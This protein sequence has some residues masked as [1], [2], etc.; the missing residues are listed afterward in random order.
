MSRKL[1]TTI[2]DIKGIP[3]KHKRVLLAWAAF[4]NN[5]GTNI[6]PAKERVAQKA[7]INRST[8]YH[9]TEDLIKVGILVQATSHTCKIAS[10]GKGGNHYT[11]K[12][13]R[14][15]VVYNLD[16]VKVQNS[17]T[18]L[19]LKQLK[20]CV[21]KQLKVNVANQLRVYVAKCDAT[22]ALDSTHASLGSE[23]APIV[24][25]ELILRS[26]SEAGKEADRVALS[27]SKEPESQVDFESTDQGQAVILFTALFPNKKFSEHSESVTIP[28]L[29][30]AVALMKRHMACY[31]NMVLSHEAGPARLCEAVWGH[32]H[33][34]HDQ[35]SRLYFR[36]AKQL[37][38][39][40]EN[41]DDNGAVARFVRHYTERE[42]E[43]CPRCK[44]EAEAQKPVMVYCDRH[45]L[46]PQNKPCPCD[47]PSLVPQTPSREG[48]AGR[49]D[50]LRKSQKATLSKSGDFIILDKHDIL[51]VQTMGVDFRTSD[52][53]WDFEKTIDYF[54]K[55]PKEWQVVVEAS[56][57]LMSKTVAQAMGTKA[58]GFEVEEEF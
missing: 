56:A 25:P 12:Q 43:K 38:K 1:V 20:V 49:L 47:A 28:E 18:H 35:D 54:V 4:A 37:V 41:F 40:L 42:D 31:D 30:E 44:A 11:G 13:G 50:S 48:I 10:C 23:G 15:T 45:G 46:H 36:S 53:E 19:L 8:V 57:G 7:G 2:L 55:R 16:P 58:P 26:P 52:G 17:E 33:D 24:A 39:A 29:T 32:N 5:D 14:Y 51:C 22:Q 27:G 3:G 21:A 6:Y 9:N 34:H